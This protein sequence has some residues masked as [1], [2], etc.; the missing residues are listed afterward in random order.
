MG[1]TRSCK[2]VCCD[3]T[4]FAH[5]ERTGCRHND[6][7]ACK[8][9]CPVCP[10]CG[11]TGREPVLDPDLARLQGMLDDLKASRCGPRLDHVSTLASVCA[12]LAESNAPPHLDP[13]AAVTWLA[14]E[15]TYQHERA[16]ALWASCEEDRRMLRQL[17]GPGRHDHYQH[18]RSLTHEEVGECAATDGI[19]GL[20]KREGIDPAGVIY[21][22]TPEGI[23]LARKTSR[24]TVTDGEGRVLS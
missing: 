9:R 2:G 3:G 16:E 24:Y 4:G 22:H 20:M 17:L 23:V 12:V 7:G 5:D 15:A 8:G 14:N 18:V 1:E 13:A 21:V 11:G 19:R 6:Q 10:R